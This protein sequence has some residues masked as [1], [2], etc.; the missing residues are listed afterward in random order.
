MWDSTF[1]KSGFAVSPYITVTFSAP[2]DYPYE[3]FFME[4]ARTYWD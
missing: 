1:V 2:E 4:S 3:I